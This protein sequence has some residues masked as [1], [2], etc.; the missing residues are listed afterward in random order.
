MKVKNLTF[1]S[2]EFDIEEIKQEIEK[3]HYPENIFSDEALSE[4]ALE[5]GFVKEPD[6][7]ES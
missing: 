3:Y 5:N 6:D 1:D 2:V 7:D 4:W